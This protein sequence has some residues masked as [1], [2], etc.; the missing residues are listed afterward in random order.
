MGEL[1][2]VV[3]IDGRSVSNSAESSLLDQI[4]QSFRQLI[5]EEIEKLPF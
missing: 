1:A 5:T 3:E 2:E 4:N